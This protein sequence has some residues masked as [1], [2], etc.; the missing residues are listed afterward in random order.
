MITL[1]IAPRGKPIR[2][3]PDKLA[4]PRDAPSS[5]IYEQLAATTGTSIHR[6]RVTKGSDGQ[7]VPNDKNVAVLDNGLLNGSR[8][9]VKDLGPQIA[10]STV[11]LIEYAGPLLI[12]PLM[13]A[14]RPYIYSNPGRGAFPPP[15]QVQTIA[16]ALV[17]LHYAKRELETLFVHKFSAATMPARNIFKN[18]FHYWVISGLFLGYF[19][20]GPTSPS[21]GP[22]LPELTYPGILFYIMG[23]LGNLSAHIALSNLRSRGGK[24][25][26]IPRGWQFRMVTCPNYMWE[27]LS[28]IGVTLVTR[29]WAGIVFSAISMVQMWL[30]AKKKEMRYRREFG[31]KYKKK[32][33]FLL[34]GLC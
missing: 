3:L 11:F 21:A 12:H 26:G 30:W 8:L 9:A 4:L 24:E 27:S 10:W 17:T 19:V 23:E 5:Q 31:D 33:S 15:S 20:Y 13:Y 29:S 14:L 28:W 34:P 25:R 18:S 22:V 2:R 32:R 16:C 1:D 7:V 6:I